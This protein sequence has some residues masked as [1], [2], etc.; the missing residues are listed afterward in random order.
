MKAMVLAT[1]APVER[2]PLALREVADPVP[3]PGEVVIDVLA[4]AV[5]RTD[6]H[7]VEGDLRLPAPEIVPGHQVVGTV[8][9][10]GGGVARGIIGARVGLAWLWSACGACDACRR[11][12]ENLCAAA[13]FSGLHVNGGYAEKV[14]ARADF[15]YPLPGSFPD[16][17]AAP[18]LCAGVIGLRALRLAGAVNGRG[19]TLGVYGFGASA[20]VAIQIAQHR[21]CRVF[22]FTRAQGHRDLA[23]A[24]GAAWVGNPEQA[25]PDALDHAV[26]FSPAGAHVPAALAHLA[27]GGTVA[28]AGVTMSDIPAF[29]Y[30]LLYGE[31]CVR[32]VANAT[33][34]DAREL[35]S[36]AAAIPLRTAVESAPLAQANEALLRVKRSQVNGAIVLMPQRAEAS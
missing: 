33:R 27:P 17:Q 11:G 15:V 8:A 36:L 16:E 4:C 29:P 34:D 30:D 2:R 24:L 5:C 10:V 18:L 22:V 3:G 1:A 19:G 32:S 13:A 7:T 31:R 20:H 25:P 23:R 12:D 35:L 9:A 6:L 28:C 26:V 14:R 21:G